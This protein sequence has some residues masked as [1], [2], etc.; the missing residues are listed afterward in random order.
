MGASSFGFFAPIRRVGFPSSIELSGST[1][2]SSIVLAMASDKSS[3][4]PL[5][6]APVLSLVV[7]SPQLPAI[8]LDDR[9]ENLEISMR[10]LHQWV[11]VFKSRIPIHSV[12]P[13]LASSIGA[14]HPLRSMPK[15][16]D[17]SHVSFV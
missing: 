3:S 13:S 8:R 1:T 10:N 4:E 16:F 7:G 12:Y 5:V 14:S 17:Y 9:I 11:S 2:H 15:Y 6:E